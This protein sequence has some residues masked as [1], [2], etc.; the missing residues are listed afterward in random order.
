MKKYL[1][2]IRGRLLFVKNGYWPKIHR[3]ADMEYLGSEY[4]G[5]PVLRELLNSESVVL[6]FGLGEDISF[7]LGIIKKFGCHVIGFDPTPKSVEWLSQQSLPEQFEVVNVGL[8]GKTGTLVFNAPEN[9]DFASYSTVRASEGTKTIEL[10]VKDLPTIVQEFNLKK[11]DVLKMDIEG[12]E[13]EV[14]AKLVESDLRPGQILVEFHHRIHGT[15]L[16][17]TVGGNQPTGSR[18][19]PAV[20]CE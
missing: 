7:D 4:G 10:S 1:R 20:F 16:A 3:F 9:P 12:S 2:F 17:R 14:V 8:A 19:L 13:N 6:S 11:V 15:P 5:W 18:W